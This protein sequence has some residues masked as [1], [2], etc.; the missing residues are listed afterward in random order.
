[1]YNLINT[2]TDSPGNYS[3]RDEDIPDTT[4]GNWVME[5]TGGLPRPGD[6]FAWRGLKVK[7]SKIQRNR[8][9]EVVVSSGE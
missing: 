1:M 5:N 9:T 7:V 3:S 8:V 2:K 4:V 6:H